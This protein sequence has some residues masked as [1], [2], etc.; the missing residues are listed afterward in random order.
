MD[1]NR[2][3]VNSLFRVRLLPLVDVGKADEMMELFDT[4]IDEDEGSA[5]WT[6]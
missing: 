2:L 1:S 6:V 3:I 5:A 4:A